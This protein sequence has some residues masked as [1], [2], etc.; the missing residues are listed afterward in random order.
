MVINAAKEFVVVADY[1]KDSSDLG[2]QWKKGIPIEVLPLAYKP[3]EREIEKRFGG[4]VILRMA[5]AKAGPL[6]TD[7]GNF[8]VDW[9]F[10]S[11]PADGWNGIGTAIN[12]IPGVI[13]HGLFIGHAKLAYFGM[14]DGTVTSRSVK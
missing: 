9:H 5:K 14:E 4:K 6:V 12:N 13:E 10:P 3:V 8:I 1:R 2:E 11:V 7:N